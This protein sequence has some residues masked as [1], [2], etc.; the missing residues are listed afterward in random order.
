MRLE[1]LSLK[2]ILRFHEPVTLDFRD[3]PPGLIAVTGPNGAGKS[4]LM[5]APIGGLYR[6]FPSRDKELYD[7]ATRSDSAIDATFELEGRGLYRARLNL[8]GPHRKAEA[9]LSRI[10][11]DGRAV[12]LNDGKLTTYDAAVAA[13]LPPLDDLLASVFAAQNKAGSFSALDRKGRRQLFASLLGLDR[14]EAQADKARQASARVARELDRLSARR[15]VIA[16][17]VTPEVETSLERRAQQL[18]VEAGTVDTRRAEL[19]RRIEAAT[20]DL[21]R[22]RASAAT[23]TAAVAER[24][25]LTA[26]ASAKTL[27]RDAA[28]TALTRLRADHDGE[29]RRMDDAL[30]AVLARLTSDEADT[31]LYDQEMREIAGRQR[32]VVAE[33]ASKIANNKDLLAQAETI[34]AA[35]NTVREINALL[36]EHDQAVTD[37]AKALREYRDR[38]RTLLDALS[39]VRGQEASLER[40]ERDAHS[41]AAAPFG[42][43]CAPCPL[44]ATIVTAAQ[45]ASEQIPALREAV[46]AKTAI[47]AD[48]AAV[49]DVIKRVQDMA[50]WHA[51]EGAERRRQRSQLQTQADLLPNL[52]AAEERIALWQTREK[53]AAAVA[54]RETAEAAARRAQR[55]ARLVSERA[56]REEEHDGAVTAQQHRTDTRTQELLAQANGLL[57]ALLAIEALLVRVTREAAEHATSAQQAGEQQALLNTYRREW[58]ETT[59]I[60]AR[61]EAELA[62]LDRQRLAFAAAMTD[63]KAVEHQIERLT[64]DLIDW[65]LLAKAFGRE[66]LQ[67]LEIDQAGPTVSAY[68]NDLLGS[69]YGS[70]F[71]ADLIT[72]DAKVSKG[73]DGS[74]QKEVFEL[75]IYDQAQGAAPRDL[76]DLSGGE[77]VIVEEAFRC[78]IALLVAQKNTGTPLRTLFRDETT[79]AL[80]PENAIRYVA[81]LRR[82][83]ELGGYHQVLFVSHLPDVTQLADAQVRVAEGRIA[84]ALPP[85]SAALESNLEV[86]A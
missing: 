70:R 50:D 9:V 73:K 21:D 75:R 78:S 59:H 39:T 38:E 71:T 82:V 84:I 43:Q 65:T 62:D 11:A 51:T 31:S 68:A 52:T 32:K 69:C 63:L 49:Q 20:Q 18:Q 60:R 19:T 8:D 10:D 45:R 72:Q 58:D 55:I 14:Y 47:D 41:V 57:D 86:L 44:M 77:R 76:A 40:A 81:M 24:D 26:E 27:D 66:G 80:D 36:A 85:Y 64:G 83:Q 22:L 56:R 29:R 13:L 15:D 7:Y 74:V 25:R 35:A 33:A 54:A 1:T 30:A 16:R 12:F 48:L 46:A 67:T 23:Y 42:E 2:G 37:R 79:G 6:K 5:E 3:L 28:L 34:R 53:D 61:V 17:S 4:T